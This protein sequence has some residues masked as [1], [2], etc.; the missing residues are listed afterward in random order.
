MRNSFHE[1]TPSKKW[2]SVSNLSNFVQAVEEAEDEDAKAA[3]ELGMDHATYTDWAALIHQGCEIKARKL[4][5]S[6]EEYKEYAWKIVVEA[7][8]RDWSD[9]PEIPEAGSSDE[10]FDEPPGAVIIVL[11][12]F[13]YHMDDHEPGSCPAGARTYAC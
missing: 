5:M 10:E 1:W 4:N 3:A 13:C 2:P 11:D 9:D 7:R 6:V 12:H 8:K